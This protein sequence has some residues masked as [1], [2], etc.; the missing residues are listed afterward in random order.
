MTTS[1]FKNIVLKPLRCRERL[2]FKDETFDISIIIYV[3][4]RLNL[5]FLLVEQKQALVFMFGCLYVLTH[6]LTEHI[7]RC[8]AE[9]GFR[10]INAT[11]LQMVSTASN[12][13]VETFNLPSSHQVIHL[14]GAQSGRNSMLVLS[15]HSAHGFLYTRR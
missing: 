6:T 7:N 9:G 14:I 5:V 1:G 4:V 3:L 15:L 13:W 12:I 10:I 8:V 2:R 11:V